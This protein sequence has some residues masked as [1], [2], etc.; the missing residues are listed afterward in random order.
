MKCFNNPSSHV[1]QL[2]LLGAS[3]DKPLRPMRKALVHCLKADYIA[4]LC[5]G[6]DQNS[7]F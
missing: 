3:V 2:A 7:L 6:I 1:D 4:P 5:F